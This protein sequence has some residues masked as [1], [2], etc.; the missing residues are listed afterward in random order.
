M[1]KWYRS[2]LACALD[3]RAAAKQASCAHV[4]FDIHCQALQKVFVGVAFIHHLFPSDLPDRSTFCH[5]T[6]VCSFRHA[7][8]SCP[9]FSWTDPPSKA[10]FSVCAYSPC[11]HYSLPVCCTRIDALRFI[12]PALFFERLVELHF[13]QRSIG[14]IARVQSM[15]RFNMRPPQSPESQSYNRKRPSQL[16]GVIRWLLQ[17]GLNL[18]HFG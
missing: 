11:M 18:R 2:C 9:V 3:I 10:G 1:Y 5:Y 4:P 12:L 14:A 17:Q 16:M 13:A 8:T 15:V 6:G 7:S